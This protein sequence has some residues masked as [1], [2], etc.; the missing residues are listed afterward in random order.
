MEMT[1]GAPFWAELSKLA[2]ILLFF[3]TILPLLIW[4]ERRVS[5]FMQGRLG[6]NRVGALGLMQSLADFIKLLNKEEFTPHRSR[7][8]FFTV[9]PV[10]ALVPGVLII[11]CI[12]LAAPLVLEGFDLKMQGLSL[13]ADLVF[14]IGFFSVGALSPTLAGWSSDNKFSLMGGVRAAAQLVSFKLGLSLSLLGLLMIYGSLNLSEIVDLQ[15]GHF[16]FHYMG[17]LVEIKFLPNWGVFFQPL[18]F[19]LF[20]TSVLAQCNRPPFDQSRAD[21]ELVGGHQGV[22]SGF[23]ALI[24]YVA[25]YGQLLAASALCVTLFLGGYDAVFFDEKMLRDFLVGFDLSL[26]SVA[27]LVT[28]TFFLF[29]LMKTV[30]VVFLFILI[31]WSLPRFSF[32][33]MMSLGWGTVL[34]WG[35]FNSF[36]TAAVIYLAHK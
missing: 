36:L 12:P 24:F 23:K 16:H 6:P 35:V 8:N 1:G 3:F 30:F 9:A 26:T 5:A 2:M 22:Y 28:W 7:K 19:V 21:S 10:L 20:F 31:S 13:G 34:S 32:D 14:I 33:H 27:F 11:M 18:A 17:D 25:E 15:R 4:S 29:F